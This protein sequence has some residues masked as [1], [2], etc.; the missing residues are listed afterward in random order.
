MK[1]FIFLFFVLLTTSLSA[2]FQV[3]AN[4]G[5]Q[6]YGTAN[7]AVN[8][9]NE[10]GA[11]AIIGVSSCNGCWAPHAAQNDVVIQSSSYLAHDF[12][13][14]I[15]NVY[16]NSVGRIIFSNNYSPDIMVLTNDGKVRIGSTST[17]G[18]YNLYVQNGILTERLKV[19]LYNSNYWM[20]GV[21]DKNFKLKPLYSVEKFIAQNKHLPG[22]PSAKD[23]VKDGGIDVTDMLAK[24]MGKI[25]ELYLYLIDLKKE[26]N[27]LKKENE[28][29]I[30]AQKS[31]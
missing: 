19:S 25:E 16:G 23:L 21:F 10:Q 7:A 9:A 30:E 6:Y 20:D 31:K 24:Q 26:I 28:K 14:N 13:I 8:L 22:I 18:N 4:P 3:P 11:R 27:I 5:N 17:P 15:P 2:Q 1:N 29:L 12:L